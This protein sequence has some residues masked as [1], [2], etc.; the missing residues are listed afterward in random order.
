MV[1]R[2]SESFVGSELV[3]VQAQD[4]AANTIAKSNPRTP[5]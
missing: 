5:T 2:L 4:G 3:F 1:F